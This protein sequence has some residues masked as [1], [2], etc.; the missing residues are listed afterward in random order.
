MSGNAEPR[1]YRI[2]LRGVL[3]QTLLGAFRTLEVETRNGDTIL[4][5]VLP[6]QAALFGTLAKIEALGLE[7]LEIRS[8]DQLEGR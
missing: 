8:G 5:G 4:T 6:D 7:L 2:R 3:G 1:L